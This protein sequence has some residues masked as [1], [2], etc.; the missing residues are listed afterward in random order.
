[1]VGLWLSLNVLILDDV[2]CR[3]LQTNVVELRDYLFGSDSEEHQERKL[4]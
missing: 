3:C 4:K 2:P 1:M